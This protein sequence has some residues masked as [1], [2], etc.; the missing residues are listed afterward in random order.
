MFKCLAEAELKLH[1]TK[2]K[3]FQRVVKYLGELIEG[4]TVR[5]DPK[6]MDVVRKLGKCKTVSELRHVLGILGVHRSYVKDYSKH[7]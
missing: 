1:P 2:C 5:P 7:A 4:G 6:K 3:F